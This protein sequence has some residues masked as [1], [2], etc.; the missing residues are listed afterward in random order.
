MSKS[1]E[2]RVVFYYSGSFVAE[3]SM[4]EPFSKRPEPLTV[5]VPEH[6]YAFAI[7]RRSVATIDGEELSGQYEQVGP[8]YYH[9]DSVVTTL[10]QLE[11]GDHPSHLKPTRILLSNMRLNKWPAVI[12]SRF[13]HWP[14]PF[15]A[16]DCEV[17][18]A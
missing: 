14:Q 2:W 4:S 15:D 8:I 17:L 12:W 5:K 3:T 13:G 18:P 16:K 10:A 11:A 6:A 1:T 7:N 9:P